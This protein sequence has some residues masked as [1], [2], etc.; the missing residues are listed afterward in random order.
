MTDWNQAAPTQGGGL[1]GYLWV[2]ASADVKHWKKKWLFLPFQKNEIAI[3]AKF[4]K[5]GL[6]FAARATTSLLLSFVYCCFLASFNKIIS[7]FLFRDRTQTKEQKRS[8]I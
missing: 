7:D 6:Q 8:F 5:V 2:T 1:G 4:I 3:F